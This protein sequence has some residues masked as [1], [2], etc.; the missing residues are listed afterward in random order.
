VW[1]VDP[2]T[3]ETRV[4]IPLENTIEVFSVAFTETSLWTAVRR[5]G[6]VGRVLRLDRATGQLL[7]EAE[8]A[9]PARVA[10]LQGDIFV[11]DWETNTLLRFRP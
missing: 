3:K 8:V 11:V 2:Y 5:P 1:A 6:Y 10:K 9:L 7:G 4:S